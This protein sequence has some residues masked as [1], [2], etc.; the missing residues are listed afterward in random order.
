MK[1]PH[2]AQKPSRLI[3][4]DIT[5]LAFSVKKYS[6]STL[7]KFQNFVITQVLREINL[8]DSTNPKSAIFEVLNFAFYE[9]LHFLE[10]EIYQINKI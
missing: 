1:F 5:T 2:C 9:I 10:A 6:K 7:W 3:N 4:S 8:G